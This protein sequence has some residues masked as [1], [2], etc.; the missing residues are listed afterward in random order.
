M[1]GE[2]IQHLNGPSLPEAITNDKLW[3]K[4]EEILVHEAQGQLPMIFKPSTILFTK[5]TNNTSNPIAVV[6]GGF[7]LPS[8]LLTIFFFF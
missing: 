3:S 7:E 8:I 4:L 5:E 6:S 1:I 2:A